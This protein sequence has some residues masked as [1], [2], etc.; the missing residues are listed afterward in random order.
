MVGSRPQTVPCE[1]GN[2]SLNFAERQEMLRHPRRD[3][4]A[5]EEQDN[6]QMTPF[7]SIIPKDIYNCPAARCKKQYKTLGWLKSH[8]ALAHPQC[9]LIKSTDVVGND[10]S[11]DL[12]EDQIHRID[13]DE[14]DQGERERDQ[15]AVAEDQILP[16]MRQAA[17]SVRNVQGSTLC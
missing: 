3:H 11:E 9:T 15:E 5:L 7:I 12:L 10:D 1:A 16:T 8:V 14:R 17:I 2:C 4:E 13:Q 6:L